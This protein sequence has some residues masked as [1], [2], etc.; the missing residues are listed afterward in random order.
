MRCVVRLWSFPARLGVCVCLA[1]CVTPPALTFEP[2]DASV[3]ATTDAHPAGEDAPQTSRDATSAP[4]AIDAPDA[5]TPDAIA[6]DAAHDANGTDSSLIDANGTDAN[7]TDSSLIDANGTDANATDANATDANATDANIADAAQDAAGDAGTTDAS[8]GGV[9][10]AIPQLKIGCCPNGLQCV[11][12]SCQH[13]DD[14]VN[15]PSPNFC[16]AVMNGNG[17][18]YKSTTCSATSIGCP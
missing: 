6:A 10:V 2:D 8:D 11:G 13:C 16:C 15:C 3:D 18:K 4:D 14:C 5:S 1:A 17:G 7:G 12:V 9:C